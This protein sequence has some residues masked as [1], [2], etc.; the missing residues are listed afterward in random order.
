MSN[1]CFDGLSVGHERSRL[2]VI[3]QPVGVPDAVGAIQR[4]ALDVVEGKAGL[5]VFDDFPRPVG[6]LLHLV[7]GEQGDADAHLKGLLD[8]AACR[9]DGWPLVRSV[10]RTTMERKNVS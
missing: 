6:Q 10:E 3:P 8:R 2:A 4:A 1:Q 5:A 7:P 9:S